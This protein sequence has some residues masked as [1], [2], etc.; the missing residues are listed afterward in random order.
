MAESPQ[1]PPPQNTTPDPLMTEP[2]LVSSDLTANATPPSAPPP[3]R[4]AA[5]TFIFFTVAL[6]MLALGMIAPVLPRL[7]ESFL[8]G[9][10]S[11]AARMLGLFGT[12]FA[13]M[14][15]FFSPIAGSLSDRF[16][17]RP[18]VLLSNFGLGLDYVLMA[19]AP[20]LN[21][22]FLGR[23]ISGLTSSSIPTAMAYMADVTPRERR[24]AA[25][26]LLNA[27]FGLGFVLGPAIGGLLGNINPRLPFWVAAALSLINGLYGLFVLPESLSK[28]NRSP[29]SWTRANPVG[30]LTLLRHGGM[31]GIA[32]ILLLGYIA[33]QVLMNVYVIYDDYRYHWTNRTVG[34]SLAVVGVFTVIYGAFLIK[35]VVAKLGERGAMTIGL[36]GGALGYSMIGSSK[37]GLLVWIGIPFLNLMSFTWPSAQ[38]LLSRK[39]SP[40]EQGQ[41]QGAVNGLRGIAGLI[42]PGF[43]TYIFS[44][45]I[46]IG[47]IVRTPGAPFYVAASMLLI[48][49]IVTQYATRTPKAVLQL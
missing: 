43:F 15:F 14:Q 20:A 17:R 36:I 22:L 4:R 7:I 21:W 6:D 19:W 29:F 18:V 46:G 5:A 49:L 13:A 1:N 33:Q 9:D 48:G 24:A 27:A 31:I 26:G 40:S 23:I 25:F 3:G 38:S 39:T 8:H 2:E 35:P 16:G 37:T 11:S 32:A 41:L 42:G 45:S 30:S 47:A 44:K 34:L 12:V 10:T 28:E